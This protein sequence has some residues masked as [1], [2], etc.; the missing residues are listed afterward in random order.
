MDYFN[1]LPLTSFLLCTAVFFVGILRKERNVKTLSFCAGMG[2]LALMELATFLALRTSIAEKILLWKRLSLLG[3]VIFTGNW[4]VFSVLFA[5]QDVK[6]ALKR[7]KWA[8]V[9]AYMLPLA[10]FVYVFA[11]SETMTVE[12]LGIVKLEPMAKYF[13]I[14]LV[15]NVIMIFMNLESTFR[16]S[17]GLVRWR[18]KY[19]FFGMGS[20]LLV[21]VYVLSQRLLYSMMDVQNTYILSVAILAG[22]SLISVFVSRYKIIKGDFYVSR[23]V[24]YSS[25]SLV[26]IG[27]YIILI[28][29]SA[30]VL[31]SLNIHKNLR[32]D[33][34]FI[35]FAAL[36]MV[37]LF[38]NE[39]IR[40]RI[41]APINKYFGKKK[42][43]YHDEWMIFSTEL[44]KKLTTKD[45]CESFL[46]TLLE[47]M[48]VKH[49]SLWLTD[50]SGCA[51][52]MADW[53]G[54]EQK[55]TPIDLSSGVM[56]FL[57]EKNHPVSKS[58]I[59]S[60]K[61]LSSS[62]GE[63]LNFLEE[64]RAELVVPLILAGRWVGL[65]TL[66]KIET[67]ESFDEIEEYHLLQSVA[68]HAASAINNAR[69][70]EERMRTNELEAFH[71]L[72]SFVVHDLKNTTSTLAMLAQNA[73]KHIHDPEFQKDA[74]ETISEAVTRMK[75]T[76][77]G[78]SDFPTRLKLELKDLDLHELIR[79]V[80]EKLRLGLTDF[81]VEKELSGV[82][83]LRAD[84]GEMYK[85]VH[86]LIINAYEA[87]DGNGLIKVSTEVNGDQV[88]LRVS[89]NG[90]GM[91]REFVE[92]SLF[93]PFKST[94][95]K[96][97][98]IGL[99]Q[100]KTIVEAHGGSMEVESEPG[101][102]ATFLVRLPAEPRAK[103]AE[104]NAA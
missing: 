70:F 28:G 101:K 31:R 18:I 92:N 17:A 96:G 52:Y 94:K 11:L 10:L 100:C 71:R 73:E 32:I 57:Y 20:V 79:D 15:V 54:L 38:Y 7:W 45:V 65:L 80:V 66:G 14:V 77:A 37:I 43:A 69:L 23:K 26:G 50:S 13:H 48:Y 102:G 8:I 12:G 82:P 55:G 60:K 62:N 3:E 97:L 99:Y 30:Q 63:I 59:V 88:V 89:D 9:S 90:P 24:I 27:F 84:G 61:D 53:R 33:V 75:N 25:V 86:N 2:A 49:L 56:E 87:V 67:G 6:A 103:G 47:R 35:F 95:K 78:L 81:R 68:A 72:S 1:Y 42:Y 39:R 21:Y 98:G 76:I 29:L 46:N 51:L 16:A 34:L 36:G 4:V 44:S 64:T 22:T 41:K 40:R 85:V 5:K 91:S 83:R 19:V 58:E 74:L 104:H 93:Q